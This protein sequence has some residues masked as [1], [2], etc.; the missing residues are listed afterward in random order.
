MRVGVGATGAA[1]RRGPATTS[2]RTDGTVPPD[3]VSSIWT[4]PANWSA[5]SR[6]SESARARSSSVTL[7][8][9]STVFGTARALMR[10]CTSP[11]VNP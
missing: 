10:V 6:A 8:Y 1:A 4:S 5:R 7:A 9:S 3:G 2:T 11:A